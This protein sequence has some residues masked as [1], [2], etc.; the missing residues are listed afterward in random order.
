MA[1]TFEWD[2][3]KAASNLAKHG[4]AFD[5]ALTVF[6]DPLAR[7]DEDDR[8]SISEQRLLLLGRSSADRLLAVM[9]TDRGAER[10][11]LISAR[12]ATRAE[13]IQYE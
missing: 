10:V 6:A 9:F 7:L 12:L 13:R 3:R 5:E 1:L 11:R 4:V 2:A 8:H